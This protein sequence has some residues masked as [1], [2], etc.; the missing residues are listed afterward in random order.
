[1][2]TSMMYKEP[3]KFNSKKKSPVRKRAADMQ[4]HFS[5]EN[6]QK[7]DDPPRLT[8]LSIGRQVKTTVSITTFRMAEIKTATSNA[9]EAVSG[10]VVHGQ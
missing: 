8:S 1:M 5:D 9:S 7:A 2:Y 6:K 4:G 3:S 10:S